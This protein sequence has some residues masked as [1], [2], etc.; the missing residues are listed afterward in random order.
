MLSKKIIIYEKLFLFLWYEELS[1]H[2]K[3]LDY[4]KK[5]L[6]LLSFVDRQSFFFRFFSTSEFKTY[7]RRGHYQGM[8]VLSTITVWRFPEMYVFIADYFDIWKKVTAKPHRRIFRRSTATKTEFIV[9]DGPC[10][11]YS[12]RSVV[13]T[14]T[15]CKIDSRVNKTAC[16]DDFMA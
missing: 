7:A 5:K 1:E 8:V 4:L 9:I 13:S 3:D 16:D 10:A 15:S 2:I 6:T 11:N 12:G 14:I